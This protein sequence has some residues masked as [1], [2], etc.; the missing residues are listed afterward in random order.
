MPGHVSHACLNLASNA[1]TYNLGTL[2]E[3]AG[4]GLKATDQVLR[5]EIQPLATNTGIILIGGQETLTTSNYGVRLEI[6]VTSIPQAPYMITGDRSGPAPFLD[7]YYLKGTV[8]NDDVS[9]LIHRN[10]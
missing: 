4:I 7:D 6:P 10:L 2:L 5:I 8:N 1:V 9:V 3:A